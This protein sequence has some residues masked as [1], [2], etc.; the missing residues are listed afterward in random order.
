MEITE[1]K[2]FPVKEEKLK[3]FVSIILDRCFV[4]SDIKII[5]GT[6][7]ILAHL[8]PNVSLAEISRIASDLESRILEVPGVDFALS[9]I[10]YGEVSPHVH[11]TNYACIT[12][13][14]DQKRGWFSPNRQGQIVAALAD[15]ADAESARRLSTHPSMFR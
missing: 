9:E 12:V 2:I 13:G 1:I 5:E 11:H 15:R 4:V 6:I 3:A 7:Q 14:L 10:G 8:N